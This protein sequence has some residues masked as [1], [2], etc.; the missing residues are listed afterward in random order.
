MNNSCVAEF[1]VR[2]SKEAVQQL[3]LDKNPNFRNNLTNAVINLRCYS[4]SAATQFFFCLYYG[5]K[6]ERENTFLK[7]FEPSKPYDQEGFISTN[8]SEYIKS[9]S[10]EQYTILANELLMKYKEANPRFLDANKHP[11]CKKEFNSLKKALAEHPILLYR[12][13][14]LCEQVYTSSDFVKECLHYLLSE[15]DREQI[16]GLKMLGYNF[17]YRTQLRPFAK[18]IGLFLQA[19]HNAYE[20]EQK[21]LA[22]RRDEGFNTPFSELSDLLKKMQSQAK[23]GVEDSTTNQNSDIPA[24]VQHIAEQTSPAEMLQNYHLSEELSAF[25]DNKSLIAK[26]IPR[27]EE[28]WECLQALRKL[29]IDLN[30][31]ID[32]EDYLFPILEAHDNLQKAYN[33]WQKNKQNLQEANVNLVPTANNEKTQGILFLALQNPEKIQNLLDLSKATHDA[34]NSYNLAFNIFVSRC[35]DY[36]KAISSQNNN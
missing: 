2:F 10:T 35:K 15:K 1:M 6:E 34:E 13:I 9:F 22:A 21:L 7:L 5:A 32:C 8:Q 29:G 14:Y 28:L 31:L 4:F 19:M 3:G 25:L 20:E 33:A 18:E 23:S 12:T 30:R 24:T 26:H 36:E 27:S 16:D 11:E 17:S